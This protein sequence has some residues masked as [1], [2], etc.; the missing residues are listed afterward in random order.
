LKKK[1]AG[2]HVNRNAQFENI[3]KLR[4]LYSMFKFLSLEKQQANG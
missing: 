1:A 2:G 3:T 4:A